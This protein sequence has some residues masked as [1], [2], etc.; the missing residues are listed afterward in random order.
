MNRFKALYRDTWWLWLLFVVVGG[1][2]SFLSPI[3][4]LLFPISIVTFLWF[5]YVRFDEDGNFKG[6]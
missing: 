5:A 3:F 2:F 1:A 4:L 6:S